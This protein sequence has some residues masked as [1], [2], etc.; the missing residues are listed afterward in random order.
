[1]GIV[2]GNANFCCSETDFLQREKK[3]KKKNCLQEKEISGARKGSTSSASKNPQK[4]L[5]AL[6]ITCRCCPP[7][8]C[9]CEH[10]HLLLL[11]Q[12]GNRQSFSQAFFFFSGG[13]GGGCVVDFRDF[14]SN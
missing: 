1:M 11:L 14:L 2:H 6:T 9:N 8:L 7:W 12:A 3:K 5:S 13:V 10:S 4:I